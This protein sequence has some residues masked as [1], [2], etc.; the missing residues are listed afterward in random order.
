VTIAALAV[1]V[2]MGG[3]AAAGFEPA[4]S[5]NAAQSLWSARTDFIG[6]NSSVAELAD[7]AGFGPAGTYSLSLQTE[8]SPYVM[9]VALDTLDKPFDDVDFSAPATLMLGLVANLDQ[10]SVTSDDHT[11]SLTA[12][13]AS[14]TLGF[15]VKKLGRD[16]T[17]LAAYLDRARD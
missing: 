8:Q 16:K 4:D 10:V 9:T 17:R 6:D 13:D 3:C 7:D 2:T 1:A 5:P 12:S 11:Y 15:D 14:K